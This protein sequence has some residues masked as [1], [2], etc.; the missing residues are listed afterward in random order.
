MGSFGKIW[1]AVAGQMLALQTRQAANKGE[2][3]TTID[4]LYC[5]MECVCKDLEEAN[6]CMSQPCQTQFLDR[7]GTKVV[8][9][10]WGLNDCD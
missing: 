5:Q 4:V 3:A 8:Q 2:F 1:E 7:L 10:C 6:N 9:L